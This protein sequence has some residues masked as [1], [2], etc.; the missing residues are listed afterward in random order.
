M[1]HSTLFWILTLVITVACEHA[2]KPATSPIASAPR[3]VV[4]ISPDTLGVPH[5]LLQPTSAG[6]SEAV[7]QAH[8]DSLRIIAVLA[9]AD[10]TVELEDY[11]EGDLNGDGRDDYLVLTR[12][13]RS[14]PAYADAERSN[15]NRKVFILLNAGGAGLRVAGVDENVVGCTDCG[16]AGVGDPFQSFEAYDLGFTVTQLFGACDKTEYVSVFTYDPVRHDWFL[17]SRDESNY[18]CND[19]TAT[20][21]E[22]HESPRNFGRVR[23]ADASP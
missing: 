1:R 12:S 17:K 18:S 7:L 21:H 3:P 11:S 15:H 20:V 9:Q 13:K 5:V 6:S 8:A 23:F 4:H 10:T 14:I 16:G 19:T 22:T 2:D